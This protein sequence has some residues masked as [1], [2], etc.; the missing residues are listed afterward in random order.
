M[1]RNKIK[2]PLASFPTV[3]CLLK[4]LWEIGSGESQ[5]L[6][7]QQNAFRKGIF[8]HLC[9]A[10]LRADKRVKKRMDMEERGQQDWEM[11][12][13]RLTLERACLERERWDQQM[14]KMLLSQNA[15]EGNLS[16]SK[17]CCDMIMWS[18]KPIYDWLQHPSRLDRSRLEMFHVEQMF[19][20][21]VHLVY[22]SCGTAGAPTATSNTAAGYSKFVPLFIHSSASIKESLSFVSSRVFNSAILCY[23]L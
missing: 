8:L 16:N 7:S 9:Q 13:Q 1:A 18:Y 11:E 20:R 3:N 10:K 4:H 12:R 2:L 23:T 19:T 21:V 14:D 5:D 22:Y 17:G 15:K 6:P